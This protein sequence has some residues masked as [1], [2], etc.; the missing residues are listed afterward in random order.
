MPLFID[1]DSIKKNIFTE[2]EED[3]PIDYT[4]DTG[5]T[6]EDPPN[7]NNA[8]DDAAAEEPPEEAP[9]DYIVPDET[10]GENAE[11]EDDNPP[12]DN[13]TDDNSDT[14]DDTTTDA[15]GDDNDGYDDGGDSDDD[16]V[17]DLEKDIFD[18]LSEDQMKI[19]VMELRKR[20]LDLYENCINI[21]DRLNDSP[22]S[23]ETIKQL[24]FVSNKLEALSNMVADYLEH[25]FG[26]ISYIENEVNFSKFLGVLNGINDIL[27][28]IDVDLKKKRK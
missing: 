12:E 16:E 6:G 5:D 23:E 20:Y 4:A 26:I 22:K 27:D 1:P 11:D 24:T 14:A 10:D 9:E 19:K 17:K 25:T 13:G 3:E 28:M 8:A 18:N 15:G 7:E 21:I 2:A